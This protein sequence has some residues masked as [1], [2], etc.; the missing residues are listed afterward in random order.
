MRPLN[1]L[2]LTH[3]PGTP[4]TR[5]RVLQF[6]PELET[7]GLRCTVE[8]LRD[9]LG[10]LRQ[11]GRAKDFD[12]VVLQ[13]RLLPALWFRRLRRSARRLLY[14][15]DDAV[16][17]S[18][19]RPDGK[20]SRLRAE[21]FRRTVSEADGVLTSNEF[22]AE[23]ARKHSSRVTI[24]PNCLDLSRRTPMAPA[25]G[26]LWVI[27]WIGSAGNLPYLEPLR[28]ALE[29]LRRR[30]PEVILRIVCDRPLPW[31]DLPVHNKRFSPEAEVAD[32]QSFD[33]GIAVLPDDPWTRGKSPVKILSY[34][35]A[36]LPIVASRA[37]CV[38]MFLAHDQNALLVGDPTGWAEALLRVLSDPEKAESLAAAARRTVEQ[39]FDLRTVAPRYADLLRGTPPSTPAPGE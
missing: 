19:R 30:H 1:V 6:L 16:Y 14:D 13:R 26:P 22:L 39:S 23:R 15:F 2:F 11:L 32:V 3:G 8:P 27:G 20:A 9:G 17:T 24:I 10:R 29:I 36:R 35:A 7:H 28:P 5:Y 34:M 38:S 18:R 25:A 37:S 12:V 4:S 33:I 21:R 31:K